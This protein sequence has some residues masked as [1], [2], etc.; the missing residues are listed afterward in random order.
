MLKNIITKIKYYGFWVLL[1]TKFNIRI[2][3][4][5]RIRWEKG[6]HMEIKFWDDFIRTKGLEWKDEFS[7]RLN[8][9]TKLQAELIPLLPQGINKLKI[10]D[11]GSG[12]LSYLGKIYKNIKLEITAIDPLANEY[13]KILQ[14]YSVVPI[15]K[16]QNVA[17][18]NISQHFK[19][20]LFDLVFARNC[21]DHS[22]S[23]EK[24]ILEMIKVTKQ[25]C[26]VYMMHKPNEAETENYSGLHQWNFSCVKGDFIISSKNKKLNF[27]KKYSSYAKIKTSIIKGDWLITEILKN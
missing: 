3:I 17:A 25:N 21:I 26:Y 6:I 10:L 23:P 22:I 14:K 19:E 16:T 9:S 5:N 4:P 20:N 2:P 15:I 1:E 7:D 18:E 11:V 8:K 12:P 24:A 27:S 13:A